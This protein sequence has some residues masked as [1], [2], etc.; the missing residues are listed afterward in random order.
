MRY[1]GVDCGLNGAIVSVEGDR[2]YDKIPMPTKTLDKKKKIDIEKLSYLLDLVD[3]DSSYFTVEDPGPHA[4][5]ASGLRSMTYSFAVIEALLVAKSISYTTVRAKTWQKTFFT[6]PKGMVE[7]FDTKLA[8]LV[9]ASRIWPSE[10]W[11][12]TPRSRIAFDGYIDAALLA[13]YSRKR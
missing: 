11:T 4:P 2:I 9:T 3:A 8:A 12:R 6:K 1:Y 10:D 7:K 5:S 13:E